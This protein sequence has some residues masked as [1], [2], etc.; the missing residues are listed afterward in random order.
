[1]AD[2]GTL[3]PPRFLVRGS[4]S[5]W[6]GT[7]FY[8]LVKAVFLEWRRE[9]SL[10]MAH[11]PLTYVLGGQWQRQEESEIWINVCVA[12]GYKCVCANKLEECLELPEGEK[13]PVISLMGA[14][15]CLEQ[16]SCVYRGHDIDAQWSFTKAQQ[17][18]TAAGAFE[19]PEVALAAAA[20]GPAAAPL[21]QPLPVHILRI[22]AES[23]IKAGDSCPITLEPFTTRKTMSCLPCGH[24]ADHDALQE[25]VKYQGCCPVC[26]AQATPSDIQKCSG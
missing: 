11:H 19:L 5:G 15:D 20:A 8:V 24:L 13:L 25:A 12:N 14:M 16:W 1:M 22:V 2:H 26:R 23:A 21:R 10:K 4:T 17:C 7:E 3:L 9:W 18:E 6:N